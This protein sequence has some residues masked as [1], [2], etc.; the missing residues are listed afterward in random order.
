MKCASLQAIAHY[1]ILAHCPKHKYKPEAPSNADTFHFRQVL[2]HVYFLEIC[3]TPLIFCQQDRFL[4]IP[5]YLL[6]G[7]VP[8]TIVH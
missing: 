8:L 2:L 4:Y 5:K 3:L 7:T 1:E 6:C